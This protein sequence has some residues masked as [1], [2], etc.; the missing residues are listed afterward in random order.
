MALPT[1]GSAGNVFADALS[2]LDQAAHHV[3]I[4]PEV[5]ERLRHPRAV[6]QVSVPVR[7]DDGSLQVFAGY[8]V[9]H[10]DTRGPTKG[11]IR[12]HS[13]VDLDEMKA[14][15]FWMT[16]KCA[17]VGV[18]FGGAKGGV[19]CDPKAL[20]RLELERLSRGFIGQIHDFIGPETDVAAPDVYTNAMVM[21][22]MMD[23]YSRIRR[24]RTPDVITGKPIE[25]GGSLGRDEATG[26]GA[27]C[28]VKEL[29]ARRGWQP[30]S[31][32][33]AVQGFG[34]AGQHV[35]ACLYADGYR[36]VA[37]SDSRGGIHRPEGFD[38]PSLVRTKN[39]TRALRAVYCEGSVCETVDAEIVSNA[40][41]LELDV[42]L[43]VPAA[44]GSQITAANAAR[45]RAPVVV[46]VANG[47]LTSEADAVLGAKG[48]TVV[49]DILASAGGVTVSY[50]EWVQ[51]RTGLAWTLTEVRRRLHRTMAE[52]FAAV[53]DLSVEAGVDLR[54]AA[55]AQAL[56]RIGAAVESQGTYAWF[57]EA[58]AP[59]H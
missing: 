40:E 46:E 49:P 57:T 13:E 38:V 17:V 24:R 34:H 10:D 27:Y 11:G 36:V 14:L 15:A 53:W 25:L 54:T 22:W 50:L 39:D 5:L 3:D 35:A 41:L 51:N 58:P 18:P 8:R 45:V 26:R 55:Y 16:M 32:R 56:R 52:A 20:S 47:P 37:V 33:V 7:M 42:D 30:S 29:E 19:V 4:D 9:R 44:L 21:G 6:L 59:R 12:F 43:L 2:R 28:C 23:E 1:G 48:A 31:V